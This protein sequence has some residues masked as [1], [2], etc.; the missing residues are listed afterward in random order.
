MRIDGKFIAES[1]LTRLSDD[2][3][4]LKEQGINP[5]LAVILIGDNPASL[6]YIKQ[7]QKAAERI[8][9]RLVL[10]HQPPSL[11]SG[12]LYNLINRFN[13]DHLIHGLIVQ[14]PIPQEVGGVSDVLQ[15]IRKEKDVDGFLP[16]SPFEV[17]VA[18]AI[19]E[20]L[21]SLPQEGTSTPRSEDS[22]WH[23]LRSQK[24]TIIGRGET[25]GAPI[26][27]YFVK[28]NCATSII[29][30]QTPNP[31]AITAASDIIISCVGKRDAI[32]ASAIRQGATLISVGIWR[33]SKG[34]LNGDYDEAAIA[35][36]ASYYT[37]TPGGVGPINVACLMKNLVKAC[38]IQKGGNI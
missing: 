36:V 2:V 4:S 5:T 10:E 15:K 19:G 18:L 21:R 12:G 23:W 37:P 3:A 27:R 7:K 17:P 33:D 34:K 9:A 13:K 31:L 16:D 29:H 11:T 28:H 38:T 8:G 25:A 30:S 20:I 1:L 22:M 35:D 32:V 26:S 6:A 14:R 24:I